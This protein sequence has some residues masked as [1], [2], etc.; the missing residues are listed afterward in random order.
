[1]MRCGCLTATGIF[2]AIVV[3]ISAVMSLG[4]VDLDG[5]VQPVSAGGWVKPVKGATISQGFGC[6]PVSIEPYDP[7]CPTRHFHSGIDLAAG[8][9]TTIYAAAPGKVQVFASATGFGLH[10]IIDHGNGLQ[11]LYGHMSAVSVADG[12]YVSAGDVIGSVG[13]TGNSTGPHL[14]FEID[15]DGIPENPINDLP[16][17]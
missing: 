6:T 7:S 11:S 3:A 12:S 5:N 16:L 17:P 8:P 13:S 2:I 15:R 14:H 4:F 9:G 10:V 1:M